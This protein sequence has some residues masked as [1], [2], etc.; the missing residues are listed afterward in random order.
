MKGKLIRN[1]TIMREKSRT[2]GENETEGEIE[3]KEKY[4]RVFWK[5]RNRK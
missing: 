5:E 4:D 3:M 1:Q 2:K